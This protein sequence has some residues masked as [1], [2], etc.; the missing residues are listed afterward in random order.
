MIIRDK[1]EEYNLYFI[2]QEL[3]RVTYYEV[4]HNTEKLCQVKNDF[5]TAA[6]CW[7]RIV[8]DILSVDKEKS[9]R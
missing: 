7:S 4:Y 8:S 9:L 1:I 3:P 6:M 2:E 5:D